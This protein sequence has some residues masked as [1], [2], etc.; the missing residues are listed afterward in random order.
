MRWCCQRPQEQA[1]VEHIDIDVRRLQPEFWDLNACLGKQRIA[2]DCLP[3]LPRIGQYLLEFWPMIRLFV[4]YHGSVG[5][6]NIIKKP[7]SHR[8]TSSN[9]TSIYGF[10]TQR[11]SGTDPASSQ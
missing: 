11:L 5:Y 8:I 1:L 2:Y 10:K 9:S 6:S 3:R 4:Y 7:P